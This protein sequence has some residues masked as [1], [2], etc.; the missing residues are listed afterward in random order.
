MKNT[1]VYFADDHKK[2]YGHHYWTS[3][4]HN[5]GYAGNL[6]NHHSSQNNMI[7]DSF[8]KEINKKPEFLNLFSNNKIFI[9]IGCG[10]GEFIYTVHQRFNNIEKAIGIDISPQ[11]IEYA[12]K[13]YGN[14]VLKYAVFNCLEQKVELQYDVS[15]CSNT[16]EHFKKPEVLIDNMLQFSKQCLILVPF[17]QPLTDG[18]SG[19]GGAGHVY[20]FTLDSFKNY[21]IISHFTFFTR[22]WVCGPNPLQLAIIIEKKQN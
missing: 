22:G 3:N 11:S 1:E 15:L 7:T 5:Q 14:S 19:E 8:L 18:Y 9:E 2:H 4:N 12:E 20:R 17:N 10:T 16:L 6:M 21:K 13:N